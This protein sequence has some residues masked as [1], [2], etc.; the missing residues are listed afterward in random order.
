MDGQSAF[1]SYVGG[2]SALSGAPQAA[3]RT[4]GTLLRMMTGWKSVLLCV[5]STL[6]STLDSSGR[7][8][9]GGPPIGWAY[10][11]PWSRRGSASRARKSPNSAA[12]PRGEGVDGERH[13]VHAEDGDEHGVVVLEIGKFGELV[14]LRA[15]VGSKRRS[16]L[17]RS[18]R[19]GGGVRP[20]RSR[21]SPW[22]ECSAGRGSGTCWSGTT[23]CRH[24][25]RQRKCRPNAAIAARRSTAD[26]SRSRCSPSKAGPRGASRSPACARSG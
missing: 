10:P 17:H 2:V 24:P 26:R 9:G 1:T 16:P 25:R 20:S 12:V 21:P 19:C 6:S 13:A 18:P 22:S 7:A 4:K 15:I 5:S 8:G 14:A 11:V 23:D 3:K